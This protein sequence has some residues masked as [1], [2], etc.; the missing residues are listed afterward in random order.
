MAMEGVTWVGDQEAAAGR[1]V[2]QATR[3]LRSQAVRLHSK[4]RLIAEV[5]PA[6]D[7]PRAQSTVEA[8]VNFAETYYKIRGVSSR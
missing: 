1:S 3:L 5:P 7:I 6:Y 2:W 4:W 8:G